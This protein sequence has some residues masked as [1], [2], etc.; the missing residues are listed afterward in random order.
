MS[1][2]EDKDACEFLSQK[3]VNWITPSLMVEFALKFSAPSPECS[4]CADTGYVPDGNHCMECS[5]PVPMETRSAQVAGELYRISNEMRFESNRRA[6]FQAV[7]A[8]EYGDPVKEIF[9]RQEA[10]FERCYEALGINDDR[11]R[12]WS[13]LVLAI[14]EAVQARRHDFEFEGWFDHSYPQNDEGR[15]PKYSGTSV[16][17]LMREAFEAGRELTKKQESEAD[18]TH[19]PILE[20]VE[21]YAKD[22]CD[23][24]DTEAVKSTALRY[25][26]TMPDSHVRT[27]LYTLATQNSEGSSA[28]AWGAS[29]WADLHTALDG[30]HELSGAP[31]ERIN[32]LIR[33]RN[34]E[35]IVSGKLRRDCDALRRLCTRAETEAAYAQVE[36]KRLRNAATQAFE[37]WWETVREEMIQ[38]TDPRRHA[39]SAWNASAANWAREERTPLSPEA[40]AFYDRHEERIGRGPVAWMDPTNRDPGQSVTFHKEKADKWP[41][42]YKQPLYAGPVARTYDNK[43]MREGFD[44]YL[45]KYFGPASPSRTV[46]HW[47]L[48]AFNEGTKLK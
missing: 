17:E 23:F 37:N 8:R 36:L 41:H 12:S 7:L 5:E 48:E 2:I 27:L 9:D 13:S 14:H 35:R 4:S 16:M 24:D 42:I 47:L 40:Q 11:E 46:R 32:E 3:G 45:K 1:K 26:T 10:G 21:E 33:Q 25:V 28:K 34:D 38:D 30:A 22:G 31:H 44:A 19:T 15:R 29:T 18:K 43:A 6:M 39:E 20:L